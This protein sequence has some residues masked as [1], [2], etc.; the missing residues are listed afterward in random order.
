MEEH[1]RQRNLAI[2]RTAF[3]K[4]CEHAFSAY[5]NMGWQRE[6]GS[7]ADFSDADIAAIEVGADDAHWS[8]AAN[9]RTNDAALDVAVLRAA[10]ELHRD[11]CVTNAT[12]A[13]LEAKLSTEQCVDMVASIGHYTLN[14]MLLN[15]L[16][17]QA[18]FPGKKGHTYPGFRDRAGEVPGDCTGPRPASARIT[19]IEY[20]DSRSKRIN[21]LKTM[22]KHKDMNRRWMSWASYVLSDPAE[23]GRAVSRRLTEVAILRVG[24][25]LNATYEWHQHVR[26]AKEDTDITD[27]DIRAIQVGASDLRWNAEEKALLT[28]VD[29]LRSYSC[30]SD[31]TWAALTAVF[32][33]KQI[34]DLVGATGQYTLVSFMLNSFGV[35]LEDDGTAPLHNDGTTPRWGPNGADFRPD[36]H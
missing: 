4:N 28:M 18:D 35:E 31:A 29:E 21:V 19:P 8:S 14:S 26:M 5:T 7:P 13:V 30:V 23:D 25:L 3:L 20:N 12:W 16:G 9:N 27:D 6:P 15:T 24:W 34:M 1:T 32:S 2:S 17:V 33:H 10:D 22:N 11:A 36:A